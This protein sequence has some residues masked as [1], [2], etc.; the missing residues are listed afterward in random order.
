MNEINHPWQ[1]KSPWIQELFS[2]LKTEVIIQQSSSLK[3]K[4]R[5]P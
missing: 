3:L 1:K 4:I 2:L 5:Q